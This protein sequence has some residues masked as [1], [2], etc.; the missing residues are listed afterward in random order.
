MGKKGWQLYDLE[1]NEFFV[2]QDVV[3]KE[4]EFLFAKELSEMPSSHV[5]VENFDNAFQINEA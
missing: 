2:S 4:N 5:V 1:Q 3:F